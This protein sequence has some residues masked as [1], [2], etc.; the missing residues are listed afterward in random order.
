MI[1]KDIGYDNTYFNL[2]RQF[3][4]NV[5]LGTHFRQE[6]ERMSI[7]KEDITGMPKG[8]NN[9]KHW[10]QNCGETSNPVYPTA[11]TEQKSTMKT[12]PNEPINPII[13]SSNES[14]LHHS[15]LTKREFFAGLAMQGLLANTN[16]GDIPSIAKMA[17]E[18]ADA[19]ILELNKEK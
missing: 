9:E 4:S 5:G 12:E 7:N 14:T 18:A 8:I 15:G 2:R 6:D 19:L 17:V 13:A 11:I 10:A 1:I 16:P 3:Y